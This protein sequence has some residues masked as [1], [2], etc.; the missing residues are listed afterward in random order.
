MPPSPPAAVEVFSSKEQLF[1]RLVVLTTE[2]IFTANPDK[3]LVAG[4]AA[5]V[6][7]TL[8]VK[9]VVMDAEEFPFKSISKVETN[10]HRTDLNVYYHDGKSN[11]MKNIDFDS[12]AIRDRVFESLRRRLGRNFV[13]D[14]EQYGM[15]RAAIAPLVT[16]LVLAG[17]TWLFTLAAQELADGVEP[18]IR[19]RQQLIKGFAV[20]M[21]NLLGPTGVMI[22]GGLCVAGAIAWL[23][24]RVKTPPLMATLT[25][26]K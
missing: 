7:N 11:R 22:V 26:K 17:A 14:E 2:S 25:A 6:A 19:G 20:G 23:V 24:A 9:S 1:D 10:R 13:K 8:A 18:E 3:P 4:I 12:K 16:A 21:M 5:K 15:G